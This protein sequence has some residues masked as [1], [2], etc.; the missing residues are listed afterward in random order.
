M[1]SISRSSEKPF[2][3]LDNAKKLANGRTQSRPR[4]GRFDAGRFGNRIGRRQNQ[5]R[6]ALAMLLNGLAIPSKTRRGIIRDMTSGPSRVPRL[7]L[8]YIAKP[9]AIAV[10]FVLLALLWTFPLQHIFAYPFV[11]LFLAAV[12]CSAWF[13]GFI[14]GLIAAALS[15]FLVGFFY[16]PPLFSFS[17][18]QEYRSYETAFIVC[19]IVVTAVSAAR[20]RAEVAIRSSRDELDARV[21]ERTTELERS[22]SE[23][24]GRER[25][26]RLLTE[27]IPQQI[28]RT[29]KDGSIEYANR[30]LLDYVGER[31]LI[32]GGFDEIFH[33]EDRLMV[34]SGWENAR[35]TTTKFECKARVCAADGAFRW[36]IIR[37]NP[38]FDEDGKV[39]CWYGVHI[40]IEDQ[41]RA[42][43]ELLISQERLSRYSRN[44]S[45][46]EMAASIAHQL[47][48]PLTALLTDAHACRRWL[49]MNP[50]N[51]ERAAISAER[52]VRDTSTASEVVNRVRS[53]FSRTDYVRESTDLNELVREFA[54]ILRDEAVR[55]NVV[56]KLEL[57]N[58]LQP[59]HVDRIQIQ[60]VM[61]NLAMNGMDAMAERNTGG[62]LDIATKCSQA[63]EALITVR[64]YGSGITP[65]IM[66]RMFEPF[67][68]T[69]SGGIGM[70]LSM[71][72]S[73]VEEHDGRIWAE[74]LNNGTA[75]H[76]T[77]RSR[78]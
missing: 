38:Q 75:I 25:Q 41:E 27:A 32:G 46:A 33:P 53:L 18:A 70:G 34:K 37:A 31:D 51:L 63:D 47:N 54:R 20:K 9:T 78:E 65:E 39:Q 30:D 5:T 4:I 62:R 67:F 49:Q 68:S 58:A 77:L 28:W 76:F 7:M 13:G 26:L 43:Q 45:M 66:A 35:F 64:D 3:D 24:R 59:V 21:R 61:L 1:V 48:Q 11:F 74:A 16:I 50:P 2:F 22:N 52:I 10:V 6:L 19:A 36:F 42:Q 69:K 29:D 73:I 14:S 60:Q 15:S 57:S 23:I 12:M 55:H 8:N 56:V 17:I 40:D 44:L 71:C 72:R